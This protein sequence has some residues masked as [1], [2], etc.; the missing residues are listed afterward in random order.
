MTF[1]I[2]T[3]YTCFQDKYH[4]ILGIPNTSNKEMK[5]WT[6][7]VLAGRFKVHRTYERNTQLR[8]MTDLLACR[9][10]PQSHTFIS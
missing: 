2:V 8:N 6:Y 4:G 9:L 10:S 7:C 3:F 5:H 1:T